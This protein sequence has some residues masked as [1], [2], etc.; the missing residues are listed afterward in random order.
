MTDQEQRDADL[1]QLALALSRAAGI[2]LRMG[3]GE[4]AGRPGGGRGEAARDGG[5]GVT[6]STELGPRESVPGPPESHQS[7]SLPCEDA[8]APPC[9]LFRLGPHLAS[10]AI[11]L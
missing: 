10:D 9:D 3:C 8:P 2:L 11:V 4:Q 5:A 1:I 7:E 6:S